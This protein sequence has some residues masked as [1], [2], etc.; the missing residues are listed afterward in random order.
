MRVY[1]TNQ[2]LE[3]SVGKELCELAVSIAADGQLELSEIE[4]LRDWLLSNAG[5]NRLAAVGYLNDI[6]S[7]IT[8]DDVINQ[9][10]LTELSRAI[11]RVIP[12]SQRLPIVQARKERETSERERL[13]EAR[14]T[15]R[16]EEAEKRKRLKDEESARQM[17][18]HHVFAKVA[19]VTFPNDDG[20]ERQEIIKRC[21]VGESLVLRRD[22]DDPYSTFAIQVLR[23]TGE[24]LGHAPDYLAETICE[25]REAG[26]KAIGVLKNL[27]GGTR[28]K[29][30]RGVNF[31]VCFYAVD[32]SSEELKQYTQ[33]VFALEAAGCPGS[34]LRDV[35]TG[36]LPERQP[37]KPW[38][39]FW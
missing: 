19:G 26:Y 14:R 17:R 8:A 23:S 27:T 33:S 25:E 20:S 35:A 11:E 32:V 37:P 4:R 28:D 7:R 18:M 24:Q 21:R 12:A 36:T 39:K 5:N 34:Q 16:K 10:E 1:L 22:A 6:M 38:W 31:F 2:E 9:D 30:T 15:I 13:K 29:P 3:S